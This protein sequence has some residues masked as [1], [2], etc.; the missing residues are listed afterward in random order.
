ME[1]MTAMTF[2]EYLESLP[3]FP[4]LKML[5]SPPANLQTHLHQ[6][7]PLHSSQAGAVKTPTVS[8]GSSAKSM[9][10]PGYSSYPPTYCRVHREGSLFLYQTVLPKLQSHSGG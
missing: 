3:W 8:F 4:L 10:S 5:A 9:Q 7:C 2:S 6:E 1:E